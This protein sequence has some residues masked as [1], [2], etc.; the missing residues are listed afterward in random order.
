[1]G[2]F[3]ILGDGDEDAEDEEEEEEDDD[4]DDDR[5]ARVFDPIWLSRR[6]ILAVFSLFYWNLSLVKKDPQPQLV[7]QNYFLKG[8]CI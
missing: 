1:M 6:V 4:D 7:I 2:G 5:D 8:F 3:R